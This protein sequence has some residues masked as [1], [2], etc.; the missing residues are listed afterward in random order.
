MKLLSRYK[1][2]KI[3]NL[4]LV[5]L[6]SLVPAV[7][8]AQPFPPWLPVASGIWPSTP[9]RRIPFPPSKSI[10]GI[11]IL[12]VFASYDDADTCRRVAA[13]FSRVGWGLSTVATLQRH[14]DAAVHQG[15][16]K[17][18]VRGRGRAQIARQPRVSF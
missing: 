9:P 8:L 1:L 10:T 4:I 17:S 11:E 16:S 15:V 14:E 5:L 2:M 3:S 18:V 13:S 6:T 7:A 12:G